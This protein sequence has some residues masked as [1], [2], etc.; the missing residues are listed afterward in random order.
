M[1]IPVSG[2]QKKD[3]DRHMSSINGSLKGF[4]ARNAPLSNYVHY[5]NLYLS[6]Y[7]LSECRTS[8]TN[9]LCATASARR[10]CE[11]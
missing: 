2:L 8:E 3:Q 5:I 11:N 1:R 7:N 4:Y 9:N 10:L 6:S